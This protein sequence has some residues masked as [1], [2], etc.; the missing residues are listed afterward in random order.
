[1]GESYEAERQRDERTEHV[2]LFELALQLPEEDKL[3]LKEQ[4]S[5]QAAARGLIPAE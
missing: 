4:V 2:R 3:A 1:L 5:T